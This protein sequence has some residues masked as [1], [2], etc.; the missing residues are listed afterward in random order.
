[1]GK[2]KEK[3]EAY[4]NYAIVKTVFGDFWL[5]K[6]RLK[7][8]NKRH[9]YNDKDEATKVIQDM[10][11]EEFPDFEPG[12]DFDDENYDDERQCQYDELVSDEE[13]RPEM[14]VHIMKI[15]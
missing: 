2:K 1:M 15:D 13:I 10:Y 9:I 4:T 6:T 3:K 11:L 7:P 5:G 14:E 8:D 12:L